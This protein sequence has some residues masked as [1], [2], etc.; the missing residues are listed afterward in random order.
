MKP[1]EA[2]GLQVGNRGRQM[3]DQEWRSSGLPL[4]ADGDVIAIRGRLVRSYNRRRLV[5]CHTS[6]AFA[7]EL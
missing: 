4:L 1:V 6:Q 5:I 7:L 2:A 3:V